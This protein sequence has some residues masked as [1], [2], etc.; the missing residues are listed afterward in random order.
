ME[1]T[2]R[3]AGR[4]SIKLSPE[5]LEDIK[6]NADQAIELG[7][8]ASEILYGSK[9]EAETVPET[10]R[11]IGGTEHAFINGEISAEVAEARLKLI[12]ELNTPDYLTEDK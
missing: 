8:S 5:E 6:E 12:A 3:A 7:V 2:P 1:R 10:E 9:T 11:L 4:F